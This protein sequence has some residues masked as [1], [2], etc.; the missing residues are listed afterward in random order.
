MI[1][2]Y[3]RNTYVA[4]SVFDSEMCMTTINK[5][6]SNSVTTEHKDDIQ[7]LRQIPDKIILISHSA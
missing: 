1:L 4:Y 6:L 2:K 3:L 5:W 7:T